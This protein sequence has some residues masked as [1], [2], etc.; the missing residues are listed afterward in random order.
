MCIPFAWLGRISSQFVYLR[1]QFVCHLVHLIEEEKLFEVEHGYASP[2][3]GLQ[4]C[5]VVPKV[6]HLDNLSRGRASQASLSR[7]AAAAHVGAARGEPGAPPAS[8]A[9]QLCQE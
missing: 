2:E 9:D 8:A 1:E 6:S 5:S 3:M 4:R 7:F